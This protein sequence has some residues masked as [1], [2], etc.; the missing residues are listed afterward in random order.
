MIKIKI[1][2]VIKNDPETQLESRYGVVSDYNNDKEDDERSFS[3]LP[4]IQ[5]SLSGRGLVDEQVLAVTDGSLSGWR[6]A[7]VAST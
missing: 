6:F 5:R 1:N 7:V 2:I 3:A 4:D